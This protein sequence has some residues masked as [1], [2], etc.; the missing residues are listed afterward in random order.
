MKRMGSVLVAVVLVLLVFVPASAGGWEVIEVWNW[1]ASDPDWDMGPDGFMCGGY[2]IFDNID[3]SGGLTLQRDKDG[4]PK[5][6]VAEFAGM[7][8]LYTLAHPEIVLSGRFG[9]KQTYTDYM[10]Q[11][12][13]DGYPMMRYSTWRGQD[14][15]I[16]VP[17]MGNVFH[18][19]G[20]TRWDYSDQAN[21]LIVKE[22][23]LQADDLGKLC[24]ALGF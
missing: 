12:T 10:G 11:Y 23:G 15:N 6:M 9:W 16:A 19:A 8:N 21:P 3:A 17:G 5:T 18:V 24:K 7:D 22:A 20:Q 2:S 1:P 13:P 4:L 14:W